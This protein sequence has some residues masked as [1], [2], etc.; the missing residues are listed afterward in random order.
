MNGIGGRTIA[1]AKGRILY[2]EFQMWVQYRNK[3]GSLNAGTRIEFG[4]A[5]LATMYANT[6]SKHGGMSVYDFTPHH[7][8]P[9]ISLEEAMKAWA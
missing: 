8:A 2:S 7:E 4:S 3:R 6:H 9:A 5:L 1:E